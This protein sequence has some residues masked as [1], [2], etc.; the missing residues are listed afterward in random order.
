[1][2][3]G[4]GGSSCLRHYDVLR[5]KIDMWFAPYVTIALIKIKDG[6]LENGVNEYGKDLL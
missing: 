4:G 5:T 2:A 6:K 3:E 1:M